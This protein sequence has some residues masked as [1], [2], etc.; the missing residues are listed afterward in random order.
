MES[1]FPNRPQRYVPRGAAV[2]CIDHVTITTVTPRDAKWYRD[3][4]GQRY[5]EY[6][7]IPDRPD[8]PV[9]CMSSVC[10]RSHDLGLVWDP[11]GDRA[12]ST[13]SRTSSSRVRSCCV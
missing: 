9:F 11:T 10:E 5:M 2:R 6:T 12:A 8:F 1:P 3:T 13:T 4:L 7:T